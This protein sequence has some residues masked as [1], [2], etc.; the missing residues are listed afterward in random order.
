M[1][2]TRMRAVLWAG[3]L[4]ALGGCNQDIQAP[5]EAVE[6]TRAATAAVVNGALLSDLN[7]GS[8]VSLDGEI[9]SAT[10]A[11]GTV[12][13]SH[14]DAELGR[15]LWR[16][17]AAGKAVLL[18]DLEQGKTDSDPRELTAVGSTLY[19][20][21][22]A[23]GLGLWKSNGTA[24][25][26]VALKRAPLTIDSPRIEGLTAVGTTLYF[27]SNLQDEGT[28][29]WK[30]NGTSTGTVRVKDIGS[31]VAGARVSRLTAL[32]S[33]LY[34]LADDGSSGLELWK[35]DGTDVGTVRVTD[36][37]TG[38]EDSFGGDGPQQLLP[39]AGG[40]LF[41]PVQG[42][43]GGPGELWVLDG[44]GL[45]Q[46]TVFSSPLLYGTGLH[47]AT[48]A[49][50]TLYFVV[51]LVHTFPGGGQGII[52]ELWKSDGTVTGTAKVELPAGVDVSAH[53]SRLKAFGGKPYFVEDG[54]SSQGLW[55]VDG[56]VVRS[57]FQHPTAGGQARYVTGLVEHNGS[58]FF[59][60]TTPEG[61]ELWKGDGVDFT[62][63]W[64]LP[65]VSPDSM[66]LTSAGG[67]LLLSGYSW[68]D[69]TTL[70]LWRSDGTTMQRVERAVAAPHGSSALPIPSSGPFLLMGANDGVSGWE[71]WKSDGTA[72][73]TG[74]VSDLWPGAGGSGFW[75]ALQ[76]GAQWFLTPDD[77]VHGRELW[78]SDGTSG[79]TALVKDL[80]VGPGGSF[81]HGLTALNG[82]LHFFREG[83]DGEELWKSD[84]TEAGTVLVDAPAPGMFR[85]AWGA[86]RV[87]NALYF[88]AYTQAT[89]TELWRGDG[90]PGSVRLVKDIAPGEEGSAPEHLRDVNG[91]LFFF[92][93]GSDAQGQPT[94]T[95][96]K[97]NGTEAGTVALRAFPDVGSGYESFVAGTTLYFTATDGVSGVELWRTTGSAPVLVRD[98][99]PGAGSSW[100]H[101]FVRL[102]N[103]VFFGAVTTRYGIELWRTTGTSSGTGLVRDVRS[104]SYSSLRVW[105]DDWDA[106]MLAV[107]ERGVVLFPATNGTGGRE[108]WWTDGTSAG[109]GLY[110]ELVPGEGSSDPRSLTRLGN[111]ILFTAWDATSGREPRVIPLPPDRT[112]PVVRCPAS[113]TVDT[114]DTNT[115]ATVSYPAA[116][117]T[118]AGGGTPVIAYST[119]S[120]SF[121]PMGATTV[122]VT[123][124]DDAG[125]QGRC[126]FTVTVM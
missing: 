66:E 93:R 100:P 92:T 82:Q 48:D 68:Q 67:A 17:D 90:T 86:T 11:G 20:T 6:E 19:F 62:K 119:P 120:G 79:G 117:A 26:T 31:G 63:S 80:Q 75:G 36:L 109:T 22:Y 3:A 29:L 118:D 69:E 113:I 59:A 24:A 78:K 81:L 103:R 126:S 99:E 125:N 64:A 107:P 5:E 41:L 85:A 47:A 44:A 30:S 110:L 46:L 1:T 65:G 98:I 53:S 76:V 42:S 13:F 88:V 43:S 57:V 108:L 70:G 116:T 8:D 60:L 15:E 14:D 97:S 9:E 2:R 89:G 51:E 28:E 50:G 37:R 61:L 84:G 7:P 102:D 45:R 91:T 122:S 40:R 52:P 58:L 25:G 71:L 95:L 87:G 33:T 27:A 72:A 32:G 4:A 115:G 96:W 55:T 18:K 54:W 94:R 49:G 10:A 56:G 23:D 111:Q 74:L 112:V 104:G 105:E 114:E 121:F 123:A 38:A 34:F 77:G 106:N 124:T 35:S 16:L 39:V 21:S 101:G 73:G 83:P 12:Y